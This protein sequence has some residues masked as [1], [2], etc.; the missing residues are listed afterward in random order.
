MSWSRS[1]ASIEGTPCALVGIAHSNK[2]A[3]LAAIERILGAVAFTNFVRSVLLSAPENIE[4][5]TYRLV[6]A[7][8]NLSTKADDLILHPVH[9]GEDY[10]DQFVKLD[11]SIPEANCDA[12]GG[13]RPQKRAAPAQTPASGSSPICARHGE[14]YRAQVI[15]DGEQAGHSESALTRA[16]YRSQSIMSR[17]DGYQGPYLWS[18]K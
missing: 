4:E 1:Q 7:K 2:K 15:I 5:R 10:R 6:H 18:L 16:A 13:L 11:W 9:V 12:D 8:H 3:D 17:R 14:S